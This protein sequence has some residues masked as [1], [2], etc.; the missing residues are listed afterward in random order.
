MTF[1]LP[2]GRG[3]HKERENEGVYGECVLY[4]YVKIEE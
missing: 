3:G 4:P 2:V 1:K